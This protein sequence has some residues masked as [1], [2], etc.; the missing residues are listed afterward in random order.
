M[1][2]KPDE[3]RWELKILRNEALRDAQCGALMGDDDVEG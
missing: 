2:L 3:G 1:P